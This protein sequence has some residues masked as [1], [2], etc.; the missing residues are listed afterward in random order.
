MGRLGL[1]SGI[2]VIA[3]FQKKF[4]ARLMSRLG[5]GSGSTYVVGRLKLGPHVVG[6]L[7]SGVW[8]SASFQIFA[9]T[10]GERPEG[11]CP[12]R[13][14]PGVLCPREG[15]VLHWINRRTYRR[16]Y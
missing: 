2:Q 4:H 16:Y 12:G 15:N 13:E 11:N 1:G 14:C 6:R 8:V 7:G 9:L 3:S 5:L 10:A